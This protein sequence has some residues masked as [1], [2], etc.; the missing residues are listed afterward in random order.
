METLSRM[1]FH[2]LGWYEFLFTGLIIVPVFLV[3]NR[4]PRQPGFFLITFL[5]LYIPGRFLL[6]FLRLGDARYAGLT[7]AQYAGGGDIPRRSLLRIARWYSL[8]VT[9][10]RIHQAVFP[11]AVP[12]ASFPR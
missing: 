9:S 8:E 2:D 11:K 3:L 4:K 5:L 10:L 7:P 12:A 6:D 1:G